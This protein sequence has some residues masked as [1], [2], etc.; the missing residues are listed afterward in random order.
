MKT[1][2]AVATEL[3]EHL[4]EI[5]ALLLAPALQCLNGECNLTLQPHSAS[6]GFGGSCPSS[7]LVV[8]LVVV[9][10]VMLVVF[11]VVLLVWT[12]GQKKRGRGLAMEIEHNT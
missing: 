5:P 12:I 8:M 6:S 3:L 1:T 2:M 7:V 10:V 11:L 4:G 9:L